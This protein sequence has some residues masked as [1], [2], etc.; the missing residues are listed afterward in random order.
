MR[1][2]E[3]LNQAFKK[4]GWDH[5]TLF[6][7]P[8]WTRRHFFELI[9]TGVS[10][11]FLTRKYAK[12]A[13][14]SSAGA[15][16]RGSA[17]NVIF[18]LLAGA[19][20]HSDTFDLKIVPGV[21]PLSFA[22]ETINGVLWPTG[23]L[24]K[25]GQRLSDFAIVRS[26][27]A[28][29]VVH[30]L[31]QVWTQIGRNPVAAFGSL[32]PNIGSIVAIEKE[33]DR[34][35]GQIFPT[36]LALNSDG[37]VGPGYLSAEYAPFKVNAAS[38]GIGNTQHPEGQATFGNRWRLLRS[39]DDTLRT[40][41]PYGKTVDDYDAFYAAASGLMYNPVVNQAFAYTTAEVAR[42]GNNPL[43]SACVVASKVLKADQGTRF[44]QITYGGWDMHTN[45]Y[46]GGTLPAR[47]KILDDAVSTLLDDL[48]A[49]GL[50]DSTMI[51]MMG[52]FGRTVGPLTSGGGRDHW[53]QQFAFFAGGGVRGGA[54]IGSTDS[55]GR[56]TAE[57]GW[58]QS[59]YIWAED[60]EATI[61][62]AL[63]IDWTT[64]RTDDPRMGRGFEYVPT[65]GPYPFVP[66]DELW[67]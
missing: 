38:A 23:L 15:S 36:F 47:G 3:K 66:V 13:D 57:Y 59:R 44:I 65:N 42:Y 9:G 35:P 21:T 8:H 24:P 40:D 14:L 52:E 25:L 17:R 4:Y 12:A 55:T 29:A 11:A 2:K 60:I 50:Y 7:R 32:A 18:I 19:P 46:T 61:Y 67:G 34:L 56:D 48:K 27:R 43:G 16:P 63:G 41:S 10:G 6:S 64:L 33:K 58:S 45:I 31:A 62:S 22:P 1:E 53:A 30:S 51:V 54:I 37:A 28:H 39:L 20:S 5:Q 49:N 26:V